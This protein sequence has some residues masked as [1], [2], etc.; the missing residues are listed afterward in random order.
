MNRKQKVAA[1]VGALAVVGLALFPPYQ[2]DEMN[3]EVPFVIKFRWVLSPPPIATVESRR[4]DGTIVQQRQRYYHDV[5]RML[6]FQIALVSLTIAAVVLL[7]D[8]KR[9]PVADTFD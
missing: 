7:A 2:G 5:G 6:G 9:P 3:P 1:A 4:L 8:K